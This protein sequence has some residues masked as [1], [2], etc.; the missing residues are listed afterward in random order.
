[1]LHFASV[2]T[3]NNTHIYIGKIVFK[4]MCAMLQAYKN[5]YQ[6]KCYS[7]HLKSR[8]TQ[9]TVPQKDHSLYT[10]NFMIITLLPDKAL[11]VSLW[12]SRAQE[13]AHTRQYVLVH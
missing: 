12:R 13:R 10:T 7:L 9:N 8:S 6:I 3:V 5:Q 4:N 11:K 1:M 2:A